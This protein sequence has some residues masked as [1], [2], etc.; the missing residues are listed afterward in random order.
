M[1]GVEDERDLHGVNPLFAGRPA[2]QQMEKMRRE[3]FAVGVDRD[4]LAVPRIVVPVEKHRRHARPAAHRRC[5]VLRRRCGHWP[6]ASNSPE[7]RRRCAA[8][9][10]DASARA[11]AQAPAS[12]QRAN[13]AGGGDAFCM[14]RVLKHW[15]VCRGSAG[16]RLRQTRNA[17]P[18]RQC[19]I[20]DSADRC[21]YGR[22]CRWR[23]HRRRCR[24]ERPT[25]WV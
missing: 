13:C 2:M 19:R 15:E 23:F 1:L 5:R 20:H 21:R 24:K 14:R 22:R 10:W 11:R 6:L 7:R 25:F 18:S 4:A 16:A 12:L 3:R 9:P 17:R 8:R